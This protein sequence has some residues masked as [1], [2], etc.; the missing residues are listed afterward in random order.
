MPPGAGPCKIDPWPTKSGGMRNETNDP[1]HGN[2]ATE[3][4]DPRV[5][6]PSL[7]VLCAHEAGHALA[8]D[9][10]DNGFDGRIIIG[11][12]EVGGE[13]VLG[14]VH[15]TCRYMRWDFGDVV[16]SV[17]GPVAEWKA[18]GRRLRALQW[19]GGTSGDLDRARHVAAFVC[20]TRSTETCVMAA[21]HAAWW[22]LR[23]NTV[24]GRAWRRLTDHLV[25]HRT[26]DTPT[27]RRIVGRLDH[28]RIIDEI[29]QWARLVWDQ[30]LRTS[31]L[32]GP[33][34]PAVPDAGQP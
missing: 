32:R 12:H 15:P 21:Q 34:C 28:S 10:V 16:I 6:L 26:C 9:V 8:Y 23:G 13:A 25:E 4:V 14:A 31:G 2:N 19:I 20:P 33:V 27:F 22:M 18:S 24:H 29:D 1:L 11:E 30:A 5:T 7:R 17:A 3:D